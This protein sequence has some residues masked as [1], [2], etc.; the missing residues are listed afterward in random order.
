MI[1]HVSCSFAFIDLRD[2]V[3]QLLTI[4]EPFQVC[5]GR[6]DQALVNVNAKHLG[7]VEV[8]SYLQ[9]ESANMT[10]NIKHSL[11]LEH[12]TLLRLVLALLESSEVV[13]EELQSRIDAS[14]VPHSVVGRES[15]QFVAMHFL[16]G[17][18][19]QQSA[20]KV[21]RGNL[22]EKRWL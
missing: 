19:L 11:V 13:N 16:F 22:G 1:R 3:L 7:W 6:L 21:S 17:A 15:A 14:Q 12:V 10:S 4:D 2:L 5:D 9:C 8:S 20:L 18:F